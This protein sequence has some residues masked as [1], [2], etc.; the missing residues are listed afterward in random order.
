M[1]RTGVDCLAVAIGTVHE[2]IREHRID[3]DLL[4]ELRDTV[5]VP[6]VLH[7]G[8]GTGEDNLARA[9]REGICKINIGTGCDA[10]RARCG[11]SQ[12]GACAA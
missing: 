8:S 11:S 6:L 7:G 12:R 5:N 4:H 9:C 2:S 10:G 1:E 3:F